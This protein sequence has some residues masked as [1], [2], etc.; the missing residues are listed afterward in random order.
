MKII[1]NQ[2]C[3]DSLKHTISLMEDIKDVLL[4]I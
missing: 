3:K 4:D 2:V 1:Q